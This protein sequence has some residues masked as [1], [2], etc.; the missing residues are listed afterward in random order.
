M[1][2]PRIA[3]R[4]LA[5][6]PKQAAGKDD[7]SKSPFS[8]LLRRSLDDI[9]SFASPKELS[10]AAGAEFSWTR[11]GVSGNHTWAARGVVALPYVWENPDPA[12]NRGYLSTLTLAPYVVFDRVTN[13]VEATKNVD[14]LVFGFSGE[15][16]YSNLWQATH[17]FRLRSEAVSSFDG[18]KA[19]NWA[20][21]G[22]Y[23][24]IGNPE[25]GRANSLFAY[26]GTPLPITKDVYFTV[27]PKLVSE[28]RSVLEGDLDPIFGE[29][30][31]AFRSG[32]KLTGAI[33]VDNLF[34]PVFPFYSAVYQATYGWL[35]D[36]L[37]QRDYRLFDTSLTLN[38]TAAGNVGLTLS[39]RRGELEET[40]AAVDETKAGLAVK[41]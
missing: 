39:Y 31:Q 25:M 10:D 12:R 29:R 13:T 4:A 8:F 24:P 28:F 15:A 36:S 30:R 34:S 18:G 21:V 1:T 26:L 22:E 17:I 41:F 11:N 38:M 27:T 33:A 9:D 32:G 7:E 20:V 16:A 37:S 3:R 19:K 14:N 23:L 2:T 5:A 35:W 6:A 40:G